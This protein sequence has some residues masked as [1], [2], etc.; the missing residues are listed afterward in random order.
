[1]AKRLSLP[2]S[3]QGV[4]GSNPT[5]GEILSEFKRH[6]IA[7]SPS[8]S[9]FPFCRPDVTEI[10]LKYKRYYTKFSAIDA[11]FYF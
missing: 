7:Q 5:G 1:M 4:S 9:L 3:D 11:Y 10:L 8:C 2:T 6:F